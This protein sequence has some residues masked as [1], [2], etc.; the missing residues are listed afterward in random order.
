MG[1]ETALAHTRVSGI[2]CSNTRGR[3]GGGILRSAAESGLSGFS[4]PRH[5]V[6]SSHKLYGVIQLPEPCSLEEANIAVQVIDASVMDV[7]APV[8]AETRFSLN[9]RGEIEIPFTLEAPPSRLHGRDIRI[10]AEVLASPSGSVAEGDYL[11]MESVRF[12]SRSEHLL[13]VPVE[14]ITAKC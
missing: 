9:A 13:E 1:A 7:S 12:E 8:L 6:M 3:Y 11:T 2:S 10:I 14:K 5:E 4:P